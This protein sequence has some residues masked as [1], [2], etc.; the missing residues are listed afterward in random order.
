[1]VGPQF[2]PERSSESFC[3]THIVSGGQT[4]VDR[5]GLEA[6][7]AL[8]LSHGGWCPRGR[9]AE[10]GVVPSRFEL[11]ENDSDDYTVRTEQ[12]VVDSDATLILYEIQL[13]GGTRLTQRLA[14]RWDRPVLCIQIDQPWSIQTARDWLLQHQPER[15]NVAGPRESSAPGIQ[16]R[17]MQALLRILEQQPH[18]TEH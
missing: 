18:A 11:Q 9:L 16:E 8:G 2:T 7:I 6:A 17:A 3:P 15:L 5:A 14:R 10:D 1:M 13:K 4:G 12:N